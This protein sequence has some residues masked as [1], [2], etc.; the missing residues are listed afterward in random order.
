MKRLIINADDCGADT[1]RNAGIF[2]A[3]RKNTVT[4][5]SILP[6]GPAFDD[7]VRRIR[8]IRGKDISCGLHINLSEG[9]PLSSGLRLL[10]TPDGRFHGKLPAIKLFSGND[11]ALEKEIAVELDAQI[12]KLLNAGIRIRHIDSHH[13]IHTFPAVIET[14]VKAAIKYN[15]PRMRIPEEPV[16]L[17]GPLHISEELAAEARI[18]SRYAAEARIR[19]ETA[20]IRTTEHFRGLYLKGRLSLPLMKKLLPTLPDGLTE[21]MTH[22]GRADTGLSSGPFS[23]FSTQDRELELETLL[24]PDFLSILNKYGVSLTPDSR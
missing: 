18:F 7:A 3:V 19:I 4:G 5:I 16:P 21:L 10:T 22:P 1:A 8:S 2:E 14:A 9:N 23:A 12:K 20:G 13:H 6:N 17:Y 11:A 15:I 24:H